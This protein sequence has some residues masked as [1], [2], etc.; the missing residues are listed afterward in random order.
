[1]I[2]I[3]STGSLRIESLPSWRDPSAIKDI[4]VIIATSDIEFFEDQCIKTKESSN[5]RTFRGFGFKFDTHV[6]SDDTLEFLH[7]VSPGKTRFRHFE[8]YLPTRELL[9]ASLKFT[10]GLVPMWTEKNTKDL[11]FY[12]NLDLDITPRYLQIAEEFRDTS[13]ANTSGGQ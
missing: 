11:E 5:F 3:G 9:W 8:F 1:M 2:V 12:E 4:D 6:M 13:I 7:S 10:T